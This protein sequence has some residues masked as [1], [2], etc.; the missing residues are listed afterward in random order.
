MSRDLLQDNNRIIIRNPIEGN[1][2]SNYIPSSKIQNYNT[3]T[4]IAN[5]SGIAQ[6]Y[7]YQVQLQNSYIGQPYRQGPVINYF[8]YENITKATNN[9]MKQINQKHRRTNLI[10]AGLNNLSFIGIPKKKIE[11]Y[12]KPQANFKIK[13]QPPSPSRLLPYQKVVQF[14]T[15]DE[16][17]FDSQKNN[18]FQYQQNNENNYQNLVPTSLS[19]TERFKFLNNQDKL[20][21]DKDK[22]EFLAKKREIELQD[23]QERYA[24]KFLFKE[25]KK[26]NQIE[27]QQIKAITNGLDNNDFDYTAQN[28][29]VNNINSLVNAKKQLN[30]SL[31]DLGNHGVYQMS[32]MEDVLLRKV[33]DCIFSRRQMSKREKDNSSQQM[34]VDSSYYITPK[35]K[36][37]VRRQSLEIWNQVIAMNLGNLLD[38]L[39][40]DI[41]EEN[42]V[43]FL[44][45]Y[46]DVKNPILDRINW[47]QIIQEICNQ[48]TKQILDNDEIVIPTN[49]E[50]NENCSINDQFKVFKDSAEINKNSSLYRYCDGSWY[51][52]PRQNKKRSGK[53][54]LNFITGKI[55]DGEFQRGLRHGY[56]IYSFVQ[57]NENISFEKRGLCFYKGDFKNDLKDGQATV[58]FADGSRFHGTFRANLQYHGTFYWAPENKDYSELSQREYTGYWKGHLMQGKGIYSDQQEVKTGIFKDSK[59]N[60]VGI[61][62]HID[63]KYSMKGEF[64]EDILN[65]QIC[66]I[67]TERGKYLG[68]SKNGTMNG[69]GIMNFKNGDIYEG[70]W[71]DGKF[72]GKGRFQ[73][74]NGDF[75][76]GFWLYGMRNGYGIENKDNQNYSYE[77]DFVNDKRHGYALLKQI[78][79]EGN[80]LRSL[81]YMEYAGS[82]VNDRFQGSGKL[83][84]YTN[85]QKTVVLEYYEGSFSENYKKGVGKMVKLREGFEDKMER[86]YEEFIGDFYNDK[87]L[88]NSGISK[89]IMNF[90]F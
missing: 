22:R 20:K 54:K 27:Q 6:S 33:C 35:Y 50:S 21:K 30:V 87:P 16:L 8:P 25:E 88:I 24:L 69:Q 86:E 39:R 46:L 68:E 67:E 9:S 71:K 63:G 56:G 43:I 19:V 55:Y 18:D 47:R 38:Q 17:Y 89:T 26:H 76:T 49:S 72:S 13:T 65:G 40:W 61:Q 64:S 85:K 36:E 70:E 82:F 32:E 59:L 78:I 60:G 77:G 66:E 73:Q 7:Q 51:R 14:Q 34:K 48:C 1:I 11:V 52:G 45:E 74:S 90:H 41:F 31:R 79:I 4:P 81:K 37:F 80:D 62:S 23:D 2:R 29:G 5:N 83:I 44:I 28:G 10:Q 57:N 12:E 15:P 53:G 84:I 75:Y 58:E 3:L 42:F